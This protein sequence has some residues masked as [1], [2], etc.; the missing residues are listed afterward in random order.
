MKFEYKHYLVHVHTLVQGYTV[1]I[2]HTQDMSSPMALEIFD[3][4]LEM[5]IERAKEI[6]DALSLRQD[7]LGGVLNN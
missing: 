3:H 4:N 5:A 2:N 1:D 7:A 6:V